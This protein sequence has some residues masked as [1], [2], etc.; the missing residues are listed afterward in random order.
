MDQ[1]L[2]MLLQFA[3]DLVSSSV[4]IIF[5]LYAEKTGFCMSDT[6][7]AYKWHTNTG[8]QHRDMVP[9][10]CGPWFYIWSC[11]YLWE[12]LQNHGYQSSKKKLPAPCQ[13]GCHLGS[14]AP[15]LQEMLWSNIFWGPL[16][17]RALGMVLTPI[18]GTPVSSLHSA[19]QGR[20]EGL[21]SYDS[22]WIQQ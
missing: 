1:E 21:V 5:A 14:W 18:Y 12:V 8:Y 20:G 3:W 22:N 2:K 17:L 15:P 4:K 19:F 7:N 16:S 9:W 10:K 13:Q 11:N 6:Q